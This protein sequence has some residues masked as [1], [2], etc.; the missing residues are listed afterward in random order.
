MY[1]H[2]YQ[3][4]SEGQIHPFFQKNIKVHAQIV[5]VPSILGVHQSLAVFLKNT[6]WR[7]A[8]AGFSQLVGGY[9]PP[10]NEKYSQSS[11]W[12]IPRDRGENKNR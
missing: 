8:S 9:S 2:L 4:V 6:S 7:L 12:I 11:K 3:H 1:K 10:M 5:S